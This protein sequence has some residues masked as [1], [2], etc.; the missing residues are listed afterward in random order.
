MLGE[1]AGGHLAGLLATKY[2]RE[3]FCF[4]RSFLVN[5][6]TELVEDEVWNN[7]TPKGLEK[8]MSPLY[9]ISENTSPITLIHGLLDSVVYPKHSELFCQRMEEYG[10]ECDVHWIEETNHAFLLAE[11]T[12][13]QDACR[14]GIEIIDDERM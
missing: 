1:S 9:N 5:A 12:K 2:K 4:K 11:H 6:I 13:N 3:N 8:P 10:C 7:R 14:I